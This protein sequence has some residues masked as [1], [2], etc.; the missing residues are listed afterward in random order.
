M[1][2]ICNNCGE[3]NFD[4]A[5]KCNACG[6]EL[7]YN[8]TLSEG[9]LIQNRYRIE[10][11]IKLGGMGAVYLSLDGRL[12]RY[13]VVKEML[14]NYGSLQEKAYAEKRFKVEARMLSQLENYHLPTVYDYFIEKGRYYLVMSYIEGVD[15]NDVLELEGTPGLPEELV[16]EWSV[17]ILDVLDYLHNQDPPVVYRDIKPGNIMLNKDG[18]VMLI[19]F[20]IAR[21]IIPDVNIKYTSIGTDGYAAEEQYRGNVE[22]RSDLYSL[23]ATMHH[24]LTGKIPSAFNLKPVRNLAPWVSPGIEQIVMKSLEYE[25]VKRYKNAAE[26]REALYN[27]MKKDE[28]KPKVRIS[29]HDLAGYIP[30]ERPSMVHKKKPVSYEEIKGTFSEEELSYIN[31]SESVR[32]TGEIRNTSRNS[33]PVEAKTVQSGSLFALKTKELIVKKQSKIEDKVGLNTR[34]LFSD[35]VSDISQ[36]QR[37]KYTLSE[38]IKNDRIEGIETQLP[39]VGTALHNLLKTSSLERDEYKK[40]E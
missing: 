10:Q 24:L 8:D 5:T 3:E 37:D 33:I 29:A 21:T 2:I 36:T 11:L 26:M 19:D 34:S 1:G 31:T 30:G 28:P 17:Q 40:S 32:K 18:R 38:V 14:S 7:Y 4:I 20:G 25:A 27:L 39:G 12:N 13:C 23:G 9:V 6:V 15:L 16:I 22:P 35:K